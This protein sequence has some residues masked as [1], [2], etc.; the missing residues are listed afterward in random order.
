VVRSPGGEVLKNIGRAAA[1]DASAE[2]KSSTLAIIAKATELTAREIADYTDFGDASA[3]VTSITRGGTEHAANLSGE[4][5]GTSGVVTAGIG[6][7]FP[8]IGGS[9]L[10]KAGDGIASLFK[11][12]K[13]GEDVAKKLVSAKLELDAAIDGIRETESK[14]QSLQKQIDELR[15]KPDV[16]GGTFDEIYGTSFTKSFQKQVDKLE[17]AKV[18]EQM[19]LSGLKNRKKL[20]QKR[21][22]EAAKGVSKEVRDALEK[23]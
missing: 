2:K 8:F 5:V 20:L 23:Y 3:L 9:F 13:K 14:I 15:Q 21:Y 7:I 17:Q 11:W 18:A 19:K 16:D 22:D 6:V 4:K 12:G 10:K 1:E